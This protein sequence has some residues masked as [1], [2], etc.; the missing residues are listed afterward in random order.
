VTMA[1]TIFKR[2]DDDD[3]PTKEI[4][5]FP[6]HG[7]IPF[8]TKIAGPP[9]E[10]QFERED[11]SDP[12]SFPSKEMGFDEDSTMATKTFTQA[13]GYDEAPTTGTVIIGFITKTEF[14]IEVKATGEEEAQTTA[15]VTVHIKPYWATPIGG[16]LRPDEPSDGNP[17]HGHDPRQIPVLA[18]H[19]DSPHHPMQW[20]M[21]GNPPTVLQMLD[22]P[23]ESFE[24]HV[25]HE[26]KIA[27][28]AWG[29]GAAVGTVAGTAAAAATLEAGKDASI[30]GAV[31]FGPVGAAV[32]G[33]VGLAVGYVVFHFFHW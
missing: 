29:T 11:T 6:F 18:L 17:P 20:N 28:A 5:S 22:G 31:A 14:K 2:D 1:V 10:L 8:T 26:R 7:N 33:V 16:V 30:A 4:V 3:A 32:G 13:A 24:E 19:N 21:E 23:G 9:I 15:T 25:Q 27:L 12:F